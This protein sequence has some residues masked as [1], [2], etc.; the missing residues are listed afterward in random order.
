V[1][2]LDRVGV[3]HLGEADLAAVWA[4]EQAEG[5]PAGPRQAH[6]RACAECRA[7][8]AAFTGWL[9]GVRADGLA[10]ADEAFPAERL[11]AQQSHILR[12]LDVLGRPAKVLAFPRF[13]RPV[14]VQRSGRQRWIAS[15]AAAGLLVGVG[16]GQF[17]NFHRP[18]SQPAAVGAPSQIV[19]RTPDR[20]GIQPA[21][22]TI[23]DETLLYG[24]EL[25]S[26]SARVP[27]TLRPIHDIT[28]G[29][30]DYDPR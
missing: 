30:R 22:F 24:T 19:A 27:E 14:S 23:S 15:A 8:Y 2:F 17:V 12:R 7:R 20:A 1:K 3:R 18:V 26:S 13:A 11:A 6:L 29:G 9:D 5:L 16:L 10:E 25:S 4:D 28:P 21:S